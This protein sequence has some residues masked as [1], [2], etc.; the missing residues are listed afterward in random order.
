M[1]KEKKLNPWPDIFYKFMIWCFKFI[2]LIW[3]PPQRHLK[4]IPLK[5]GYDALFREI[6]RILKSEGRIFINP[7]HMKKSRVKGIVEST[8]LFTIVE[9]RSRDMVVAPRA[10]QWEGT[11]T[12]D[13]LSKIAKGTFDKGGKVILKG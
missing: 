7:E 13:T 6:H 2:D 11:S 4:R 5:Q 1:T 10:K 9:Y 3:N 12:A 8:G